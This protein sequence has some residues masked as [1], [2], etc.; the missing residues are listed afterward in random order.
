M[1]WH[2]GVQWAVG[3]VGCGLA[4]GVECSGLW[5]QWAVGLGVQVG[6]ELTGRG[7]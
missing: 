6:H 3:A 1:D 2:G 7:L 5:V 4:W